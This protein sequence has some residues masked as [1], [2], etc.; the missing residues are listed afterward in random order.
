MFSCHSVAFAIVTI[1]KPRRR[2]PEPFPALFKPTH[3]RHQKP[4]MAHESGTSQHNSK[5]TTGTPC[6]SLS[7]FLYLSVSLNDEACRV[8]NYTHT[9]SDNNATRRNNHAR[10]ITRGPSIA[11][12]AASQARARDG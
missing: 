10:G 1:N 6:S 12:G 3:K 5:N 8:H 11:L 2:R 4:A 7:F 9:S